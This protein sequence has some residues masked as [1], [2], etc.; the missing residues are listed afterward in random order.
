MGTADLSGYLLQISQGLFIECV[1]G[2]INFTIV[3]I[4][5]FIYCRIF[6]IFG[7][8]SNGSF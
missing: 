1:D 3:P 4:A 5:N 8:T 7:I 2:R 6:K